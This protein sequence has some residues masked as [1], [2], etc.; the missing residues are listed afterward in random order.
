MAM[1]KSKRKMETMHTI[2]KEFR[3]EAAHRLSLHEGACANIHGH[4]YRVVVSVTGELSNAGADTD[5][6]MDFSEL[7]KVV[8]GILDTGEWNG[9]KITPWDHALILWNGDNL[10]D[11]LSETFDLRIVRLTH[12]PTAEYMATLLAS[13]IQDGLEHAGS[14]ATV[15]R[16]EVW[17]TAKACAIWEL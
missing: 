12:Q 1:A 11:I 8:R 2:Q 17:E 10:I 5:M 13:M 6:V 16:V 15:C 14:K 7:S 9:L 4:S 3:F